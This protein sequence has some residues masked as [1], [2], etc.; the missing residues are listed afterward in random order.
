MNLNY[1]RYKEE[2]LVISIESIKLTL[3]EAVVLSQNGNHRK[4]IAATEK[5]IHRLFECVHVK[6]EMIR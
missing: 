6:M 3:Q 5:A 2:H 4:A 1:S